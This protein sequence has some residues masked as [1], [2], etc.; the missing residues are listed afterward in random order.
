[1]SLENYSTEHIEELAALSQRLSQDPATRK[2]FLRLTKKVHPDLAV[3]EIDMEDV[4]N[5]RVQAAEQRTL[6]LEQKLRQKEVR[7]ELARRRSSLKEKGLA[8]SDEDIAQIEKLMTEKGIA[9]H[10]TA[11]DYWSH[12]KQAARPTPGFPQPVMSRLDVKGY[13]KNPVAAAREN[14]AQALNELRKNPRPIGL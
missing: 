7:E 3:P 9:N 6:E 8:S 12:M 2:E 10:E 4:V 14:A 1:M 11:A 13:M 5:R